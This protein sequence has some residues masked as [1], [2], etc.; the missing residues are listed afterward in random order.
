MAYSGYSTPL[1]WSVPISILGYILGRFVLRTLPAT[2]RVRSRSPSF[3]ASAS[4]ADA[5]ACCPAL[6]VMF[7]LGGYLTTVTMGA[8]PHS[9][10][11]HR[12]QLRPGF[13]CRVDR[14]LGV[15]V[16]CRLAG[17]RDYRHDHV[18]VLFGRRPHR[19]VIHPRQ[20]RRLVWQRS[21]H[22]RRWIH[23]K[24]SSARQATWARAQTGRVRR[25]KSGSGP[26][27]S[28]SSWGIVFAISPWQSSRYLMA[29]DEHVVMRSAC[30][31]TV[32]LS[33]SLARRLFRGDCDCDLST[34]TSIPPA[35]AMIW[36]ALNLMPEVAGA[37]LLAGHHRCRSFLGVYLPVADRVCGD[38]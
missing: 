4:T 26:S 6:L 16:L 21:K 9:A 37:L 23:A 2:R 35:E 12:P 17:R 32:V 13:V 11:D 38:Q 28:R 24:A 29:R 34:L 30:I 36:A 27:Y 15:H 18:P 10:A 31:T 8:G 20:F 33:R 7:G 5:F 25:P 19:P 1:I 14:L 22:S 3:S